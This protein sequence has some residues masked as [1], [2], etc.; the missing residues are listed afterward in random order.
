MEY[1]NRKSVLRKFDLTA[2]VF[3]ETA[4]HKPLSSATWT[5]RSALVPKGPAQ[6]SVS[7]EAAQPRRLSVQVSDVLL[8][9]CPRDASRP[10]LIQ[11]IKKSK[12][13]K[14]GRVSVYASFVVRKN[15]FKHTLKTLFRGRISLSG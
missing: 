5:D 4:S 11:R 3:E 15:E 1:Q 10:H 9:Q 14:R 12:A 2:M 7:P 6:A 13:P 8:V